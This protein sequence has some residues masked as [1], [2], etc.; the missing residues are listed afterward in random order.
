MIT[1]LS[2]TANTYAFLIKNL[3]I[4]FCSYKIYL[5]KEYNHL[6][7]LKNREQIG[8]IIRNIKNLKRLN[9]INKYSYKY[10]SKILKTLKKN[11][12]IG[13]TKKNFDNIIANIIY[14]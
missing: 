7:Y 4:L 8:E 6:F 10:K 11:I 1:Y 14:E 2:G 5:E 3:F 9:Y 12:I 13:K